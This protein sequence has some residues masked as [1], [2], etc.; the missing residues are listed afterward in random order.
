MRKTTD[1][2]GGNEEALCERPSI[3]YICV[4]LSFSFE[5]IRGNVIA[6]LLYILPFLSG[7]YQKERNEDFTVYSS[8]IFKG[9]DTYMQR[10]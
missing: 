1:V 5:I 6:I 10:R 8:M 3:V 9:N 4:P 2:Q 7:N